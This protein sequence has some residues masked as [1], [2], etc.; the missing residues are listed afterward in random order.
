MRKIEKEIVALSLIYETLMSGMKIKEIYK[1]SG[2]TITLKGL[3][4]F[5]ELK[6][7]TNQVQ[8]LNEA[9]TSYLGDL[10][11]IDLSREVANEYSYQVLTGVLAASLRN[12]DMNYIKEFMTSFPHRRNE[13]ERA[14]RAEFVERFCEITGC[15]KTT[16]RYIRIDMSRR[17]YNVSWNTVRDKQAFID[18]IIKYKMETEIPG[19]NY[20]IKPFVIK[21]PEL[22]I[23]FA[24]NIVE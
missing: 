16:A 24:I 6:G 23:P 2:I 19:S 3:I 15:N 1:P 12:V 8:A 4:T 22:N 21:I 9:F 13:V 18:A 17:I 10:V 5:L 11:V 7:Y 20:I 14:I